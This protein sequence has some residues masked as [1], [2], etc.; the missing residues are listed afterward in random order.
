MKKVVALIMAILV[1]SL[2][3]VA[4]ADYSDSEAWRAAQHVVKQYLEGEG[5]S[6]FTFA[7]MDYNIHK[8]GDR[9]FVYSDVKYVDA[10]FKKQ[11]DYFSVAFDETKN[12]VELYLMMIGTEVITSEKF[13]ADQ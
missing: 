12:G 10:N 5:C 2:S 6:D 7:I 8:D 3:A 9:Y 11:R 1:I 13:L 4:L